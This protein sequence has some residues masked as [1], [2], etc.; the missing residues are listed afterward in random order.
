MAA[1][2]TDQQETSSYELFIAALSA[3]SIINIA[4]ELLLWDSAVRNVITIVDTGLCVAFLADFFG[5]LGRAKSKRQYFFRQL[6]WLDLL[7]SLPLPGLRIARVFRVVRVVRLIR[8]VGIKPLINKFLHDRASSALY[9]VLLLCVVVIQY[10]SI[11]ELVTQRRAPHANITTASDAVWYVI[12]TMTTVGYGDTYP[13]TNAGR[14]VG[15]L[16]MVIGVGLFGVLTGFLAN[17]FVTPK[18][19]KS[20]ESSADQPDRPVSGS[21][22]AQAAESPI[23]SPA[24]PASLAEV[25]II[26][27]L[28]Q[29]TAE[30][31]SLRRMLERVPLAPMTG[32]DGAQWPLTDQVQELTQ[33]EP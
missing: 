17:A 18:S 1:P 26:A 33:E 21:A 7:G 2:P 13:T 32:S 19:E 31:A 5:R 14:V 12:V 4:L 23:L 30:V 3:F 22:Q 24:L 9:S 25:G 16:T 20:E 8:A 28:D 29:L 15:V 11:F 6:G 10:A 27:R